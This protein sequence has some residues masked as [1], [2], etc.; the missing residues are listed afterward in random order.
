MTQESSSDIFGGIEVRSDT[1]TEEVFLDA[2]VE[3]V[4]DVD[5]HAT[6]TIL[7]SNKRNEYVYKVDEPPLD[8]FETLIRKEVSKKVVDALKYE[9]ASEYTDDDMAE[10][11]E[12]QALNI[13][14][15]YIQPGTALM[16]SIRSALPG[17]SPTEEVLTEDS[18][19]RILY[20]IVRD[21][22]YYGKL[23]PVMND[24]HV[25]DISCNAPYMPVFV[26]HGDY[27]DTITNV[28][29]TEEE[30]NSFIRTLAQSSGK[31][32]SVADPMVDGSLPDGSRIQMT[33][34]D[35]VTGDG[36]NF[37]I[38]KFEEIPF[39]PVDLIN[40]GTFSLEQMA[41]L[42]LAI[43]NNKSLIFAG[44]TASGKTTSMNAISLFIPPGSKT[45]TIED[46]REI[47]LRH[48]NWIKSMT[49]D[50]F[51]GDDVGE[52]GMYDLLKAALRQRPEYL[53]VG[54][55]RGEE[56]QTLFQAMSTGH[57]TYSTMHADSVESAIHRLENP[58]IDVPRPMLKA[59]DIL[60]VQN[61]TFVGDER[62]RRNEVTAEITGMDSKTQSINTRD[63]FEWDPHTDA[64]KQVGNSYVLEDIQRQRAW[65]DEELNWQ[66]N[67]RREVLSYMVENDITDYEVVT[68]IIRS[69]ILDVEGVYE[70]LEEGRLEEVTND[71]S[72]SEELVDMALENNEEVDENDIVDP[73]EEETADE[74]VDNPFTTEDNDEDDPVDV[75]AA[76]FEV[77]DDPPALDSADEADIS[78]PFEDGADSDESE[79]A[80]ADADAEADSD[81]GSQD[82]EDLLNDGLDDDGDDGDSDDD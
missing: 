38:R 12:D 60:C 40:F 37:T 24:P 73:F 71:F 33:L 19:D 32:I 52:V 16:S 15:N 55:I 43:E 1:I 14:N 29:Y 42:W 63:V 28:V 54:E 36:S 77:T 5:E 68:D 18:I 39:T 17:L 45:I 56:A 49:R 10:I 57:T 66:L 75:E 65:D 51:G 31:H 59:L 4:Y 61:Q 21:F 34:S 25:E 20:Y 11:V 62:V 41:Y 81:E 23:T 13:I 76:E 74:V 78:D 26:Y 67:A 69:F 2:T 46:T 22:A 27:R 70:L 30:L 50:A 3:E 8:D 82:V 64:F 6:V 7:H 58:P 35:E 80:D 53:I 79:D 44:G 9:S 47:M 48:N 72:D